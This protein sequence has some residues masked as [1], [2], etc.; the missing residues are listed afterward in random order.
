MATTNQ[1]RDTRKKGREVFSTL[2]GQVNRIPLRIR[3][4]MEDDRTVFFTVGPLSRLLVRYAIHGSDIQAL[5]D[6]TQQ[7]ALDLE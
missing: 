5:A 7:A 1:P 2:M 4:D 6:A 3:R